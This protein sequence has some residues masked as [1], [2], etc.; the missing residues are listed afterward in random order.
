MQEQTR[1]QQLRADLARMTSEPEG[2][3]PASQSRTMKAAWA[4]LVR[5]LGQHELWLLL[6]WQDIKQ[7]LSLIHI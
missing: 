3:A 4:D 2:E 7:R 1:T 6:G 5:G